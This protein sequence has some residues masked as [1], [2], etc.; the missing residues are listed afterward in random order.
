VGA[1]VVA[2]VGAAVVAAVVGSAV[3]AVVDVVGNPVGIQLCFGLDS[4]SAGSSKEQP[5]SNK[6][7]AKMMANMR[8]IIRFLLYGSVEAPR[9][10]VL[11][12]T[13]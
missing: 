1:A 8:F 10:P 5:Q 11:R 7:I 2:A 3:A 4:L 12:F 6:P 9:T 13:L